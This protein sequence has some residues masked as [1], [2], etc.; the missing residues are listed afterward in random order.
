MTLPRGT[1]V[2][3]A[4]EIKKVVNVPVM[5]PGR[6]SDPN[7]AESVLSE[8]KADFIGVGR[9]L[10]ADPELPNKVAEGRV[11]EIRPCIYCNEGCIGALLV[12]QTLGCHVNPQVGKEREYKIEPTAKPK[13]V[14]VI[15][16]GP[17]GMEAARVAA[18][19]G[20]EVTLYEKQ[21]KLGGHLIEASIPE[22]KKDIKPLITWL[23]AQV[24]K[25]GADVVLGKEVTP[26]LVAEIGP[27]VAIV[28]GG[29]TEMTPEIPGVN[30]SIAVNAIDVLHDKAEVGNEVVVAGGGL[31]GCDVAVFLAEK[32]KKVTIVEMLPEIA[33]NVELFAGS[34][35]TLLLLL[36]QKGVNSVTDTNI[37]EITNEGVTVSDQEG[38]KSTIKADSVVLALGFKPETGLFEALKGKVPELYTIGDSLAPRKIGDAINEGF[39]RAI[40]I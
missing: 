35:S 13:K 17:G 31:V 22:H 9:G 40:S 23:S 6:L 33:Q 7:D 4:E 3:E 16:G 36:A 1:Y 29:A 25:A 12:L 24:E 37:E 21:D 10:I 15:G 39:Y 11:E 20:H 26:E 14:M 30:E 8:G 32:G 18:L 28:A 27:D 19:R 5:V 34:R 2:P 38:A